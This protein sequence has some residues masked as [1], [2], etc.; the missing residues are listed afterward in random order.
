MLTFRGPQ[1]HELAQSLSQV[2]YRAFRAQGYYEEARFHA[3]IGFAPMTSS[4]DSATIEP[5]DASEQPLSPPMEGQRAG[6]E[7]R[8]PVLKSGAEPPLTGLVRRLEAAEGDTLRRCGAFRVGRVGVRV[9]KRVTWI[10]LGVRHDV[11]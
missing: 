9:G 1:L 3:S 4:D 6:I 10:P 2:L 8:S 7:S 11:S 5:S